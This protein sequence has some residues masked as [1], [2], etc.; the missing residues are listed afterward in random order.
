MS[1]CVLLDESKKELAYLWKS[2]AL[3]R[4]CDESKKNIEFLEE[5][6]SALA[7]KKKKLLSFF[8]LFHKIEDFLH[9][10][11]FTV[12]FS[13]SLVYNGCGGMF[14]NIRYFTEIMIAV[15]VIMMSV[16]HLMY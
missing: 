8:C 1:E 12:K 3:K 14:V 11:V 16:E 7:E 13:V 10:I 5:Q 2:N 9:I 15:I 6:Y 4:K